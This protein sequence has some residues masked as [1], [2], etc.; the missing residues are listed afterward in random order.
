MILTVKKVVIAITHM[1]LPND[2]KLAQEVPKIDII[3]VI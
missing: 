3:L 1:R 2:E